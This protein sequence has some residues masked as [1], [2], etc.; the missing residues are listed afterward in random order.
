MFIDASKLKVV[1]KRAYKGSGIHIERSGDRFIVTTASI[2]IEADIE[3]LTNDFIAE[4]VR[5]IGRLPEE[6]V[7]FTILEEGKQMNVCGSWDM[8]Y[9]EQDTLKGKTYLETAFTYMSDPVFQADITGEV[10]TIPAKQ[11]AIFDPEK[12][13]TN[14]DEPFTEWNK[15][16]PHLV[17]RNETM[18]LA[19]W[20]REPDE[21]LEKLKIVNLTWVPQDS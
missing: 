5:Y 12:T 3:A 1:L 20:F 14:E 9:I 8:K 17:N 7:A 11:W 13:E 6:D 10:V 15:V 18:V 4:I 21:V 16:G 19:Y 2:Y